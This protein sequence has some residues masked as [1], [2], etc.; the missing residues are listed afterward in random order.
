MGTCSKWLRAGRAQVQT[1]G[2][3][4]IYNLQIF[5]HGSSGG[6]LSMG[7]CPKWLRAGRAQVQT[8]GCPNICNL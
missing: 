2:C 6:G 5:G 7:T 3:P 4:N 8:K 1:K